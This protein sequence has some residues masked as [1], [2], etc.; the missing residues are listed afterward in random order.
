[1]TN[2]GYSNPKSVEEKYGLVAGMILPLCFEVYKPRERLKAGDEYYSKPQ[3]A[4]TMIRQ[5]Q[6]MGFQFELVLADSLYG[7][8]KINFVNVLDELKLPYILAI[9]S[10]HTMWL[11]QDQQ[12][13]QEPWQRF[14][15]T[16]TFS[17]GTTEVRYM[18]LGDLR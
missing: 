4:A 15:R 12:V 11:P 13:Y 10:N 17:N 3:I 16:F 9:R 1:V 14:E 6:A 5:L 18:A 8:S 7:E 2:E